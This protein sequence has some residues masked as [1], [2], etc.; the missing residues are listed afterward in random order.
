MVFC[1]TPSASSASSSSCPN[2]ERYHL[3][4]EHGVSY[5]VDASLDDQLA[6]TCW[7]ELLKHFLEVARDLLERPFDRLIF[8]LIQYFHEF[9]DG[10]GR[11][12]EVLSTFEELITLLREVGI[13]FERF[14]VHVGKLFQPFIDGMQFL[15][16]LWQELVR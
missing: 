15:D 7:H 3:S 16:E 14:L 12:V 6:P 4:D 1:G 13:L 8:S 5:L 2:I 11:L 10:L 9:L